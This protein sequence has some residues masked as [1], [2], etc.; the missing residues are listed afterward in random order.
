MKPRLRLLFAAC[1]AAPLPLLA[2][3]PAAPPPAAATPPPAAAVEGKP[4][5][6]TKADVDPAAVDAVRKA[7]AAQRA[8]GSF[9][10]RMESTGLGGAAIPVVEMEFVFPNRMRMKMAEVEV[11]SVGDKTMMK[12]GE[13]W[14]PA[15][16]AMKGAGSS[17]GDEKKVEEMLAGVVL[18]KS[19]GPTKI[20]GIAVDA[21]QLNARTKE[22][23]SKSKIYL[24]PGSSLIQRM[25]TEA[26]V[27]GQNATSRLDYYDYGAAIR[28]ELPK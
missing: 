16:A 6:E 12:M 24:L 25:E 1:L 4:A 7:F 5:A 10:T 23:L 13:G 28:I 11:V 15:P 17:F 27:M 14:L 19:L 9:R 2:Q 18:A 20:D 21:Y 26:E 3:A 22:G 8:K